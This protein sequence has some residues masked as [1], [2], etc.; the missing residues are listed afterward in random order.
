VSNDPAAAPSGAHEMGESEIRALLAR[1][2]R[3]D[4]KG[5]TVIERAALLAEGAD[6]EATVAWI[7]AH[8]GEPEI[9]AA[10]APQRGLYGSRS[11]GAGAA[12]S[13]TPRRFV[14]PPGALQR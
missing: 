5:G 10:A 8:G 6:F 2:G 13:Q 3:R 4:A 11:E 12:G 14:L 7:L 9:R 1:L